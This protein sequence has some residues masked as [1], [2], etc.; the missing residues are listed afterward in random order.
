MVNV[1]SRKRVGKLINRASRLMSLRSVTII[2]SIQINCIRAS[3]VSTYPHTS[4]TIS[5][6][7]FVFQV[8]L[9]LCQRTSIN[10]F[11][12]A[13]DSPIIRISVL[14]F[15]SP[16]SSSVRSNSFRHLVKIKLSIFSVCTVQNEEI[17]TIYIFVIFIA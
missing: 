14:R 5:S 17:F 9:S 10:H 12:F 4:L 6:P 2:K 1:S 15:L 16:L 3:Q 11:S 8:F 13:Q 7:P